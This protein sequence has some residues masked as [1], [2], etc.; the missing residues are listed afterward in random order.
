MNDVDWVASD[1]LALSIADGYIAI[2]DSSLRLY[3]SPI[4]DLAYIG[5]WLYIE[6]RHIYIYTKFDLY[7]HFI[8]I[9][10]VK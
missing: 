4:A 2:T 10:F 9:I 3:M 8:K 5:M 6:G 7:D 1:K